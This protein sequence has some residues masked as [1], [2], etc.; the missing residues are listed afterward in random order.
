MENIKRSHNVKIEKEAIEGCK[1]LE[2]NTLGHA[3]VDGIREYFDGLID[4]FVG[5]CFYSQEQQEIY[6]NT[7]NT[8][9]TQ[10]TEITLGVHVEV[11]ELFNVPLDAVEKDT[12]LILDLEK[13]DKNT[14][15]FFLRLK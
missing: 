3:V 13:F 6:M 10:E 12:F 15:R 7:V 9:M 5:M 14:I 2:T 11:A 1:Q 4:G 8:Q